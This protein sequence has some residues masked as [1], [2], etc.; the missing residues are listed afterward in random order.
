MPVPDRYLF[1]SNAASDYRPVCRVVNYD[2][3]QR[4]LRDSDP[5]LPC[6]YLSGLNRQLEKWLPGC[7]S[8]RAGVGF[9]D[10]TPVLA[11]FGGET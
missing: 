4:T 1:K 8:S 2:Q 5:P 3:R 10:P 11:E 9:P 6:Y 7:P